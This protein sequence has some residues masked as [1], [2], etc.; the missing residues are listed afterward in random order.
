M[1]PVRGWAL[2]SGHDRYCHGNDVDDDNVQTE[3]NT[4]APDPDETAQILADP[5][6]MRAIAEARDEVRTGDVVY[7]TEAAHS[8]VKGGHAHR[9]ADKGD[10]DVDAE[11]DVDGAAWVGRLR[12]GSRLADDDVTGGS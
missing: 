8:L 7:G 10:N 11:D 12:S 3:P 1:C 2:G 6:T 9:G 5:D 4:R